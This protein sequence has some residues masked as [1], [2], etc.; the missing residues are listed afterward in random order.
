MNK[1]KQTTATKAVYSGSIP[2]TPM[3]FLWYLGSKYKFLGILS[4]SLVVVAETLNVLIFYISAHL[5]DNFTL[6]QSLLEQKEVL[7]FWGGL[8]LLVSAGNSLLYRL[9]GFTAIHWMIRFHKDGTNELYKYL[10]S[11]SHDYFSNR[12]SGALSNK[13][14]H[15]VDGSA[16]LMFQILWTFFSEFVGLTVTLILFFLIDYRIGLMLLCIFIVVLAFNI[17]AAKKRRPLVVEYAALASKSRGEG[18]D[19]ITNI[20]A[21]RQFSQ[22]R[23]EL[24]RLDAVFVDRA[25]KDVTQAMFGEWIMVVNTFFAIL[26]TGMV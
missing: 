15:A 12:F 18:V 17:I 5:I 24:N 22:R 6:S 2:D 8:F 7:Y 13:I 23:F 1:T 11:H 16:G 19:T 25:K 26:M 20:S 9:S 10:T 3:R 14:S 21:V 4:F